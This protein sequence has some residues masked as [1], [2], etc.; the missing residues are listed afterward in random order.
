MIR[1][2]GMIAY[3]KRTA[4]KALHTWT[5]QRDVQDAYLQLREA[6]SKLIDDPENEML[7]TDM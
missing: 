3:G 4:K 5:K 2:A 1:N 6:E 7:M